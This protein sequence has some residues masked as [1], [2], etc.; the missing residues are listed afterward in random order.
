MQ[1]RTTIQIQSLRNSLMTTVIWL[2]YS[3]VLTETM[4]FSTT[5]AHYK[6]TLIFFKNGRF[7]TSVVHVQ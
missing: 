4:Q 6:N 3:N 1:N 5:H 7:V 2:A